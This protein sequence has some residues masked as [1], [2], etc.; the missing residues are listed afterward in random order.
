VRHPSN[1]GQPIAAIHFP[2]DVRTGFAA[3]WGGALLKTTD[4]GSAWETLLPGVT[5]DLNSISFPGDAVT[6]YVAASGGLVL[7]TTDGG[8]TWVPK[9]TGV[10]DF[11]TSV[12]FPTSETGFVAGAS[13]AIFK[14][15][16]RGESWGRQVSGTSEFLYS[17][18]FPVDAQTG[19][20]VGRNG[21]I[22][23]T[24][25]GGA[26]V[27]ETLNDVCA[28]VDAGPTIVRSVLMIGVRGRE[29]GDRAELLDISGRKVLDLKPGANDVRAL[30][31]GVHFVRAAGCEP[32]AVSCRK[33]IV[34]R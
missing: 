9:P 24:T 1:P 13:G 8:A 2:T 3:G 34:T 10:M 7:K 14:T 12:D 17:I 28:A 18:Q 4:G 30:A 20:A 15:T 25:D 31:P 6:G 32:S 22:V 29:T 16:D 11:L 21:T 19:Y 26:A 5:N 27:E 33:V 23:K